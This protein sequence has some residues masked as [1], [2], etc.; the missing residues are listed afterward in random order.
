MR[1][2]KTMPEDNLS[3]IHFKTVSAEIEGRFFS[4]HEADQLKEA[5]DMHTVTDPKIRVEA[6]KTWE[7]K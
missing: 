5:I 1:R 6:A 7:P 4:Q 3:R 2:R